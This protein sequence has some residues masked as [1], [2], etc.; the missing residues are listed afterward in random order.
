MKDCCKAYL[1]EHFGGD[2]DIENEIY[3]EYVK[4]VAAK[5]AEADSTLAAENWDALDKVFHTI[6][7]NALMVGD[8]EMADVA[9]ALRSQANL[10]DSAACA[11]G[12]AKIKEIA[13]G[14]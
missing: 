6:K 1:D 14:L 11:A 10:H 13:A 8:Q 5:T 9:I 3:G 7:G 4:S 12:I 2:A